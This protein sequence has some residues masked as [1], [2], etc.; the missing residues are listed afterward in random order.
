MTEWV[1]LAHEKRGYIYPTSL[2]WLGVEYACREVGIKNSVVGCWYTDHEFSYVTE[3]G[4]LLRAAKMILKRFKE[5]KTF[6]DEIIKTNKEIIPEMLEAAEKLSGPGLKSQSGEGLY[7][8]YENWLNK[9]LSLMKYSVMGTVLEME[10]P[11]LS[12]ELEEILIK[13][14]GKD[15]PRVG[16][17]FQILTNPNEKTIASKE[18][19]D[20]LK[21]KLLQIAGGLKEDDI[22][23][24]LKK[25]SFIAFGYDGPS[26][27]FE[28][29]EKRLDQLLNDKDK[30][31]RKIAEK[32][33]FEKEI[34]IKQNGVLKKLSLTEEEEYLFLVLRTLGFWKF[35]RKFQNQKAHELMEYFIKEI[36]KRN[37]LS[38]AQ[39]KMI[40][41]LEMKEVLINN[42]INLELL[43]ERIK[44]SLV[45]FKGLDFEVI[46]GEKMN[47]VHREIEESLRVDLNIK[48]LKGST[49]YSGKAR[50]RIRRIDEP[51]EMS[52]M[53]K[54]DILVSASTSP[55]ILGAMKEAGAIITD[56]GGITC[57]AA[58][59]ARE[60][61]VP[62][63]IGT[64]I[65]TKILQ[66][67]DLVEVD[68][69]KGIV[70]KI[71]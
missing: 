50:G 45:V 65:A 70:R 43:N 5:D 14:L 16:E 25:Y 6:L 22:N 66:D 1:E 4:G 37:N 62:T 71:K 29:I 51:E 53:K 9:F 10:K 57:H 35:E 32:E 28:D 11:I 18:E 8:R 7:K 23:G 26:W 47:E 48:E 63:I 24:H 20:L 67:G 58:I 68:A 21:L 17:Y 12:N 42:K 40:T 44:E 33:N 64:K 55:H 56:S 2:Y 27:K 60:I 49:A 34:R 39:A 69:E 15:S 54:G 31:E 46:S 13:N 19:I 38:I 3:K 41:H 59:V 30:I 61:K 36:A 52:K